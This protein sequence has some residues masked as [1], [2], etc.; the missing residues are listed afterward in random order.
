MTEKLYNYFYKIINQIN[1]KFY[2]GIHSTNKLEDGYLGSGN[3][4]KE[5]IKK[6]EKDNFK[7]EII[8]HYPT[9]REASDHE[10][11]VVDLE[12]INDPLCYN[13]RTGGDSDYIFKEDHNVGI[14]NPMFGKKQ[15]ENTKNLISQKAKGRPVSEQTRQKLSQAGTGKT[16]HEASRKR[17]SE[18]TVGE[19]HP[20]FGKQHSELEN[21]KNRLGN[22]GKIISDEQKAAI[23]KANKGK[24]ITE[25]TRQK[26]IES[27]KIRKQKTYPKIE[28]KIKIEIFRYE[29]NGIKFH[30][31]VEVGRYFNLSRDAA[32][33]R[34][35]SDKEQWNHW[36]IIYEEREINSNNID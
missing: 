4:I 10:R 26:M 6:Y 12:M 13:C 5:A 19:N 16:H 31:A 27:W 23:S 28:P 11:M 7:K 22:I 1:G 24:K 20:M 32:R 35:H 21:D 14:K 30:N 15:K 17:M 36:K 34:C 29:V 9:R 8:N 3:A 18:N 2:F 33:G 25:Q